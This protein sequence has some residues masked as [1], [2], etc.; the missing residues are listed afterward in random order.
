M[1]LTGHQRKI[2]NAIIDGNVYNIPTYLRYFQKGEV[3]KYNIDE[4]RKKA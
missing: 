2:I 3:K 4:L 1:N